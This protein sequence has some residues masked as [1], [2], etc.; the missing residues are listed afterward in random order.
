MVAFGH[1]GRQPGAFERPTDL[2]IGPDGRI[3]VV[4]FGNDRVQV[5]EPLGSEVP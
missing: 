1:Q 5:F 4:A 2:D 3:Y